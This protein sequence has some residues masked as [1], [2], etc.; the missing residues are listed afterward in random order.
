[1]HWPMFAQAIWAQSPSLQE[2]FR[3]CLHNTMAR[4]HARGSLP[5]IAASQAAPL[6][7]LMA[8]LAAALHTEQP[9]PCAFPVA[10]TPS[11]TDSSLKASTK[12]KTTGMTADFIATAQKYSLGKVCQLLRPKLEPKVYLH[13]CTRSTPVYLHK[14]V[15]KNIFPEAN[16]EKPMNISRRVSPSRTVSRSIFRGGISDP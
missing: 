12:T 6:P 5:Q 14:C 15:C 11:T 9:I 4:G 1:M 2:I 10:L 3:I 13:K 8:K 7:A 16:L